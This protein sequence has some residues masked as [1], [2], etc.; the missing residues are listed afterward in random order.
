MNLRPTPVADALRAEAAFLKDPATNNKPGAHLA[1]LHVSG[2]AIALER[3]ADRLAC[4]KQPE[5][6]R[7]FLDQD[8]SC[9]WYLVPNDKAEEWVKWRD[10]PEEDETS[11]NEP[12]WAQRLGGSPSNVTFTDPKEG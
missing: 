8:N 10:L 6:P 1:P 4:D 2:L 11:W 5:P 3:I 9:H 7:F 12:E